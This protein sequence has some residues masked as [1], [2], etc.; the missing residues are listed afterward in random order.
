VDLYRSLRGE[1]GTACLHAHAVTLCGALP[2]EFASRAEAK[3]A[4]VLDAASATDFAL[5]DAEALLARPALADYLQSGTELTANLAATESRRKDIDAAL[6]DL[7]AQIG[8]VAEKYRV[9]L[10][11]VAGLAVVPVVN[12]IPAFWGLRIVGR[13]R[14]LVASGEPRYVGLRHDAS[15]KM[16]AAS[17]LSLVA[18]FAMVTLSALSGALQSVDGRWLMGAGLCCIVALALFVVSLVAA[19]QLRTAYE[20]DDSPRN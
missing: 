2:H 4:V 1:R 10:R 13:L 20:E 8:K 11:W 9:A 12:L 14:S 15:R 5:K 16:L 17:A 6:V 18:G 3:P 19:L 7:G